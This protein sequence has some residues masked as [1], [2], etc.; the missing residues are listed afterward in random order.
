MN[1]ITHRAPLIGGVAM[2]ALTVD[3]TDIPTAQL[4]DEAVLM[5]RQGEE[6]IS[7]HEMAHLRNSVSYDVLTS[8]RGR[9]PRIYVE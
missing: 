1:E 7:V 4:W 8:W 6:E 2:D 5:G 9:L 3:I